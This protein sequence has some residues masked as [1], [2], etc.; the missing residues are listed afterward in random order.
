[1]HD[2]PDDASLP[3]PD[4]VAAWRDLGT[5]GTERVPMWAAHWLAGGHDGPALVQLAGLHGDDPFE[6][7]AVLDAALAECG[8]CDA[9][10]AVASELESRAH[11]NQVF[12]SIAE[13]YLSGKASA[14]WIVQKVY[15]VAEPEF[16]ELITDLP[17][18]RL[19]VLDDEWGAGWGRT[20]DELRAVVRDACEQQLRLGR[21]AGP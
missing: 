12:T 6:V 21:P 2:W 7:R 15:E 17:L 16:P 14:R 3:S 19:F 1:M 5:L 9:D 8:V 11:A 18:G 10:L 13:L 4:L 20:V